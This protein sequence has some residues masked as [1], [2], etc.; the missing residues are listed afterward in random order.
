M[1]KARVMRKESSCGILTIL[2]KL[3]MSNNMA[4]HK[5]NTPNPSVIA[6]LG[7]PGK[8]YRE[9]YHNTGFLF[10]DFLI[11]K[12]GEGAAKQIETIE[13]KFFAYAR[14]G[15]EYLVWPLAF[16][17]ES[18]API[19]NALRYLKTKPDRLLVVHDDSDIELGN[20]KISFGRNAGGHHGI[21][22]IMQNLKT[23]DFWRLR[24]G[25]RPKNSA[26]VAKKREKAM[27]LVMKKIPARDAILLKSVF[28]KTAKELGL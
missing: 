25:I 12:A 1:R 8:S 6:G 5:T 9:T 20:Y 7:N 22:S 16:M 18:G 15:N 3:L 10:L 23:R 2:R 14:R 11:K 28:E 19:A 24:I 27:A 17:N 4:P 21:E 26:R 13:K